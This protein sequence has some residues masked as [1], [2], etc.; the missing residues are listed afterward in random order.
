MRISHLVR[1]PRPCLP[2][3]EAIAEYTRSSHQIGAC[4]GQEIVTGSRHAR[5]SAVVRESGSETVHL[6][7]E[8]MS[9]GEAEK[10][11]EA[12]DVEGRGHMERLAL[13]LARHRPFDRV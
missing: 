5:R 7:G 1:Q 4:I 12:I 11:G 9:S 13:G 8:S 3:M 6:A 2:T 10:E